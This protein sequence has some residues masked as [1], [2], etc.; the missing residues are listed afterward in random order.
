[1]DNKLISIKTGAGNVCAGDRRCKRVGLR[2][3]RP[4][5]SLR[6]VT[7]VALSPSGVGWAS[8]SP[9]MATA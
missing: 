1:M 7:V 3:P 9:T 5:R 4:D 8:R 2:L 6:S